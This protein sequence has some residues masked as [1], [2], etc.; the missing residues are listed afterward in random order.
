MKDINVSAKP[1]NIEHHQTLNR[2]KAQIQA[3]KIQ[4]NNEFPTPRKEQQ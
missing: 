3:D 1:Q 2:T 4:Q